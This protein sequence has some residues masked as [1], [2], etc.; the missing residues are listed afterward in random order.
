M[1]RFDQSTVIRINCLLAFILFRYNRVGAKYLPISVSLADFSDAL[2][3][4][5]EQISRSE[6]KEN[7]DPAPAS[8]R[9]SA[10]AVVL[11]VGKKIK[12]L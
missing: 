10:T 12:K 3:R 7:L 2:R 1:D 8:L 4:E 11:K 6:N 5:R 9:L